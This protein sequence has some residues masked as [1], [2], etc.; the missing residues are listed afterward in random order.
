MCNKKEADA[1]RLKYQAQLDEFQAKLGIRLTVGDNAQIVQIQQIV[2]SLMHQLHISKNNGVIALGELITT[3]LAYKSTSK[4][5]YLNTIDLYVAFIKA[6]AETMADTY[7]LGV[8][9]FDEKLANGTL[10][11]PPIKV[12]FVDPGTLET[13][14]EA[15]ATNKPTPTKH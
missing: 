7:M 6:T 14:D 10:E 2:S 3:V 11:E 13:L 8:K 15:N 1:A 4:D 9:M 5:D 12:R